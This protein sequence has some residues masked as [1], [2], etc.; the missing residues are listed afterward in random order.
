M[1]RRAKQRTRPVVRPDVMERERQLLSQDIIRLRREGLT[2]HEIATALT[3]SVSPSRVWTELQV[4]GAA[5]PDVLRGAHT[6]RKVL[7]REEA[8]RL[9]GD[10]LTVGQIAAAMRMSDPS[11]RSYVRDQPDYEAR[12]QSRTVS[13]RDRDMFRLREQGLTYVAIAK[14]FPKPD[15][16][17]LSKERVRQILQR[18]SR[19]EALESECSGGA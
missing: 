17:R 10:G 5:S 4:A 9:W 19:L 12:C 13:S 16:H 1:A 6:T 15:G 8:L 2:L 14:R 7:R 3:R 18:A 11:V